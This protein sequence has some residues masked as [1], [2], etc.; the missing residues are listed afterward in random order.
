M[1]TAIIDGSEKF[2]DE[3]EWVFEKRKGVKQIKG[4]HGP[5]A[6]KQGWLVGNRKRV[7]NGWASHNTCNVLR[8]LTPAEKRER[9]TQVLEEERKLDE[10]FASYMTFSEPVR[11]TIRAAVCLRKG[12]IRV[13][14]LE[15]E[16]ITGIRYSGPSPYGPNF[17][18]SLKH[19]G[20]SRI[21]LARSFVL[22]RKPW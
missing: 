13:D 2:Y 3:L 22:G 12:K 15:W 1:K 19:F 14:M 20:E 10:K 11:K 9:G 21:G 7:E 17:S 16:K 8:P 5:R 18:N 4:A 6:I